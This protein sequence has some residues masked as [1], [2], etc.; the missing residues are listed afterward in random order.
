MEAAWSSET[1]V[2][3]ITTQRHNA[4]NHELIAKLLPEDG[5]SMV[6]R[7]G[8]ILPQHYTVL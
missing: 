8:G 7:N 2:S 4:E 6:L 1:V 5:G 3:Y